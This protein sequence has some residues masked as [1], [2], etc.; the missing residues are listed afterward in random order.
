M[1]TVKMKEH[2]ILREGKTVRR[3][4]DWDGRACL[5][6]RLGDA[7][8]STNSS[9]ANPEYT[10]LIYAGDTITIEIVVI[11]VTQKEYLEVKI[12]QKITLGNIII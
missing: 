1:W 8:H 10:R 2:G 11:A 3:W 4:L 12:A 9:D 7:C 6:A 5:Q